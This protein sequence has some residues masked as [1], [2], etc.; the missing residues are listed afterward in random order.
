MANGVQLAALLGID[1]R[2]QRDGVSG[3]NPGAVVSGEYLSKL[4][5]RTAFGTAEYRCS[6]PPAAKVY[7][8]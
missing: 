7:A 1:P 6:P 3:R 2:I 8:A 5:T 4:I